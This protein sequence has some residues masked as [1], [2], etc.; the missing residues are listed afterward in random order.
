LA[1]LITFYKKKKYVP[2]R[3][4]VD[5]MSKGDGTRTWKRSWSTLT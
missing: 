1:Y 3:T 2:R 5:V 4:M